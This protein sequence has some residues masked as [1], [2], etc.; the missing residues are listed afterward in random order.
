M[1][2]CKYFGSVG[3]RLD[4]T[5]TTNSHSQEW[6][7]YKKLITLRLYLLDAFGPVRLELVLVN[8]RVAHDIRIADHEVIV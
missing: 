7:C 1:N 6:L 5:S 4:A 2:N 3:N 8:L